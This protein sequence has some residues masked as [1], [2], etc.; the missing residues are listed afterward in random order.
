VE[1]LTHTLN[2]A[3]TFTIL[4][5]SLNLILGYG[6][7]ASMAHA[8]FFCIGGYFSA[9]VSMHFGVNFLVGTLGAIVAT[10]VV[11]GILA[12]PFIRVREEYLILF[13]IAFQMLVFHLSLSLHS[14]TG[15]DSGIFGVPGLKFF[16]FA[17]DGPMQILPFMLIFVAL[18]YYI[19]LKITKSPF[20]RIL[21]GIRED[22]KSV[23]SLGKDVK[24]FKIIIFM[25]GT[26][27]AA[28]AGGIFAHYSRFKI[29]R[30]H[31]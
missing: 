8:A 6:G 5:V 16:G 20:G 28:G 30:A 2:L 9:I 10:A 13:T 3:L 22:E 29:G 14:I 12:A 23:I 4:T 24:K 19:A 1:Y 7:M 11:G 18:V 15:G 31:V 27:I 26:G 21:K 25:V 17:P